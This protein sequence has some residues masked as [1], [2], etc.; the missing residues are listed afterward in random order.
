MFFFSV[1][2]NFIS[3]IPYIYDINVFLAVLVNNTFS[4]LKLNVFVI[5]AFICNY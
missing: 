1:Y 5:A 4:N 3:N 2:D